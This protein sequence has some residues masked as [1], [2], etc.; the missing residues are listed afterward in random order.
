MLTNFVIS[1]DIRVAKAVNSG[2]IP[3][4]V[5]TLKL[6]FTTFL[7]DSPQHLKHRE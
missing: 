6:I 5:M 7:L 3:G 1:L 4:W 2:L